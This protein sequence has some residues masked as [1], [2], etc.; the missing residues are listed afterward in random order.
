[1]S[2]LWPLTWVVVPRPNPRL[3]AWRCDPPSCGCVEAL[4]RR[5]QCVWFPWCHLNMQFPE[6]FS[7][8]KK[9]CS[10][11]EGN[12]ILGVGLSGEGITEQGYSLSFLLLSSNL[13]PWHQDSEPGVSLTVCV[14]VC[15]ARW[16]TLRWF[17][18]HSLSRHV[19]WSKPHISATYQPADL[20][21]VTSLKLSEPQFPPWISCLAELLCRL[22]FKK[23]ILGSFIS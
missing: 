18:F 11:A 13:V 21:Q 16:R 22:N 15:S 9:T 17:C 6:T 20:G 14:S 7:S 4:F 19:I 1:M 5:K 2:F 8:C 23:D 3:G 12:L 10:L